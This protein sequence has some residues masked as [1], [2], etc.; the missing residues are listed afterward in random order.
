[1]NVRKMRQYE[2]QGQQLRTSEGDCDSLAQR[3]KAQ[4]S[5]E[6]QPLPKESGLRERRFQ[7]NRDDGRK[8]SPMSSYCAALSMIGPL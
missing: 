8:R 7:S 4:V 6:Q 1:M 2:A 5:R 3:R